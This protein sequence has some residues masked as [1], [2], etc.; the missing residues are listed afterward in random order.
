MPKI[1]DHM[2]HAPPKWRAALKTALATAMSW[3]GLLMVA[4]LMAVGGH[5]FFGGWGSFAHKHLP[6]T[7][8]FSLI[9]WKHGD[10]IAGEREVVPLEEL[11]RYRRTWVVVVSGQS[12]GANVSPVRTTAKGP[13]FFFH[14]GRISRA[15]DPLLGS[16]GDGGSPWPEVGAGLVES[17]VADAV[18]FAGASVGGS[19]VTQ[20]K[21]GGKLHEV[22][23]QRIHQLQ[24]AGLPPTHILWHQGEADNSLKTSSEVYKEALMSIIRSVRQQGM[25]GP[26]VVAVTSFNGQA[27]SSQVRSAQQTFATGFANVFVGPDTDRLGAEFRHDG[28]HWN[29]AGITEVAKLWVRA[30]RELP[31]NDEN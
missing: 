16:T 22:L 9:E 21:P 2:A 19:S 17:G 31:Q 25:E 27:D 14:K 10:P 5:F 24:D 4:C 20:W 18:V 28:L 13:V 3:R 8:Y 15:R 1:E 29:Q 7:W 30:L 6:A 23:H 11:E 12:N 26:F